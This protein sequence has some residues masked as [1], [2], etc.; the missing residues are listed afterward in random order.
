M[1]LK[2]NKGEIAEKQPEVIRP[3]CGVVMPI[4]ASPEYAASHWKEVYS[5][6]GEA[7]G[8]AGYEPSM[9]SFANESALIHKTIVQNLYDSAIVVCDVSSK[10]PNVMFELGLRL[11]FDKPTVIVKDD[12]TTYSFDTGPIEHIPYPKDLRYSQILEFKK[13]LSDKISA[14]LKASQGDP[15]YSVFLKHFGKFTVA[16]LDETEV[17]G[18]QYLIDQINAIGQKLDKLREGTDFALS[19]SITNAYNPMGIGLLSNSPYY[20]WGMPVN[21]LQITAEEVDR[22][23]AFRHKMELAEADK[24]V[25]PKDQNTD[26]S[27]DKKSET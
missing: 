26:K 24:T 25:N 9:V 8:A 2:V 12:A 19:R 27:D 14:T 21:S 10:N 22:Y 7:I 17:T 13:T 3:R 23:N 5:I 20:S 1:A 4:S 18:Q 16:K 6:L 11:A 15:D